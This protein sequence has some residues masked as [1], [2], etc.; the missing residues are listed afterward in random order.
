MDMI[1][2]FNGNLKTDPEKYPWVTIVM[3]DDHVF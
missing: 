1:K 3:H 2:D